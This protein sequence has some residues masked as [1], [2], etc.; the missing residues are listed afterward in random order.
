VLEGKLRGLERFLVEAAARRKTRGF[1]ASGAAAPTAGGAFGGGGLFAGYMEDSTSRTLNAGNVAAAGGP[2][3]SGDAP[4]V[5]RQ[6]MWN[7]FVMEEQR[8]NSIRCGLW[9]ASGVVCRDCCYSPLEIMQVNS[10]HGGL[11]R[12]AMSMCRWRYCVAAAA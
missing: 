7:A 9:A 6:R 12:P 3:G 8:N 11:L 10:V 4:F 1:K 2:L 5:K